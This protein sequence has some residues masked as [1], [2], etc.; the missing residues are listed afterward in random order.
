[1]KHLIDAHGRKIRK[2]RVS[3]TDKC[4]LRCHYCM[5]ID[6]EFMSEANFLTPSEYAEIIK[7]LCEFGLEEVRIT[8]GEPLMRKSFLEVVELISRLPL[9]RVAVTTNGVLL[10]KYLD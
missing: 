5:P 2:L 10:D 7:D 4:N 3:L 1:M 8:G 6:S 9:K